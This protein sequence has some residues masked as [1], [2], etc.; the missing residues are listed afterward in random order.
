[1][2][3]SQRCHPDLPPFQ[4]DLFACFPTFMSFDGAELQSS[5]R[6]PFTLRPVYSARDTASRRIFHET[7]R[8]T[9]KCLSPVAAAHGFCAACL[10]APLRKGL[11]PEVVFILL[12]NA[13][14]TGPLILCSCMWRRLWES[15]HWRYCNCACRVWWTQP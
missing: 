4:R 11:R 6:Q 5:C 9:F 13:Q 14:T 2:R 12:A 10:S 8:A 3:K 15:N 7:S 1:M